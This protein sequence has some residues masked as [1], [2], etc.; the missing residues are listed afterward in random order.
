MKNINTLLLY[1]LTAILLASCT[2]GLN[3]FSEYDRSI[4]LT[5][6]K[7]YAWIPYVDTILQN[8]VID[9]VYGKFLIANANDELNKKGMISDTVNPDAVFRYS[10]GVNHRTRMSQSPTVSL[11]VG[12]GGPGYY[13]G[14]AVPV[15]GGKV[16]EHKVDEAYIII[17]MFDTHTGQS[18]WT[19]GA[20]KIVNNGADSKK[21][22]QLALHAIFARLPINFKSKH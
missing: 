15:A 11:G 13:M 16:S 12:F 17:E 21:N 10:I 2:G 22:L 14:G 20:R 7:T 19:G 8:Q 1:A 3:S 6:Y 5:R 4:D 9:H 18:L